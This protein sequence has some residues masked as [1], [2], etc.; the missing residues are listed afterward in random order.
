MGNKRKIKVVKI[1]K[2]GGSGIIAIPSI[3]MKLYHLHPEDELHILLDE[4]ANSMIIPLPYTKLHKG[5]TG[6]EHRDEQLLISFLETQPKM[7]KM[8]LYTLFKRTYTDLKATPR[9]QKAL[10]LLYDSGKINM[11]GNMI[12]YYKW[13]E[14]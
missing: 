6:L 14:E 2:Q 7:S 10:R 1:K 8:E 3:I 4:D 5:K 12:F 13:I 11:K 9:F